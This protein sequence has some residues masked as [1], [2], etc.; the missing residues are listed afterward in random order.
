M[1]VIVDAHWRPPDGVGR[2]SLLVWPGLASI[3]HKKHA[4]T[5]RSLALSLLDFG[6]IDDTAGDTLESKPNG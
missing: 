1:F 2:R 3:G 5:F 6:P 4:A